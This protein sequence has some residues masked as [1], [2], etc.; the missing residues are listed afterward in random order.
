MPENK[1]ISKKYGVEILHRPKKLATNKSLGEDVYKF[2][3][4]QIQEI[5]K[6]T[7]KKLSLLVLLM[8]NAPTI[9]SNLIDRE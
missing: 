7:N 9:S 6:K 8:A 2:A 4:T 1:K 3:F 5:L